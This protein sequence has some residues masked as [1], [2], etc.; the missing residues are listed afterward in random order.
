MMSTVN[1]LARDVINTH[2]QVHAC[3]AD[4]IP[5]RNLLKSE[6]LVLLRQFR[7]FSSEDRNVIYN[8]R[9]ERHQMIA[10][11]TRIEDTAP[12]LPVRTIGRDQIAMARKVDQKILHSCIFGS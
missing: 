8:A 5:G 6:R 3:T 1:L 2:L 11:K 7:K 12:F 9:D 10:S 4:N